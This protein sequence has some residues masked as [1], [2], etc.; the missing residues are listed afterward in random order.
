MHGPPAPGTPD[1]DP[2]V[3]ESSRDE[4]DDLT[5]PRTLLM[6]GTGL[7]AWSGRVPSVVSPSP[8]TP[9]SRTMRRACAPEKT[10]RARTTTNGPHRHE[11]RRSAFR[12]E[13]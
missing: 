6:I 1:Y 9:P 13:R 10:S 8:P 7:S 2:T 11:D 12:R 4:G 3:A 5:T